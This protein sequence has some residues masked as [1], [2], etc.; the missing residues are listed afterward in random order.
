MQWLHSSKWFLPN[1]KFSQQRSQIFLEHIFIFKSYENT[2][3]YMVV[4]ESMLP[5][6][7][8][9]FSSIKWEIIAEGL[10]YVIDAFKHVHHIL[11]VE[12]SSLGLNWKPLI[13][14]H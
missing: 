12:I 14:C 1:F 5:W 4:S 9:Q 13:L 7:T 11:L 2:Q 10:H 8:E 6:E 3:P